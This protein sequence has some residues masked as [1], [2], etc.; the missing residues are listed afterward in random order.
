MKRLSDIKTGDTVMISHIEGSGAFRARLSEMGFVAGK[1]VQKVFSSPVNNPIVFKLMGSQIALRKSEADLILVT[2]PG[3]NIPIPPHPEGPALETSANTPSSKSQSPNL[4][5]MLPHADHDGGCP[6]CGPSKN[7]VTMDTPLEEG[8]LTIA[9][10]GNPNCG[11][12]SLFNAASGG[13]E[14][15]GN[16]SGV[17]VSCVVGKMVFEGRKIRFVDLPGTYSLRAFSPEEAFVSHELESG[18]IDAV[19]NVLDVNNL[20]RNL[21]LT[22][23]L[24]ERDL[25]I[26]GALNMYDEFEDSQSTLDIK[27]LG[28]RLDIPFYPTVA[29]KGTGISKLLRKAIELGDQHVALHRSGVKGHTHEAAC[30]HDPEHCTCGQTPDPTPKE[31]IQPEEACSCPERE[32]EDA[33]RYAHIAQVLDGIYM[34]KQGHNNQVTQKMDRFLA[35]RWIAYPLFVIIMWFIFWATFTIGQYP[36]DWID[37][38]VAW[39]T[40]VCQEHLPEGTLQALICDGI[41]GGVGSVIVFL[42]NILI[43]YF[44]ISILEDSGYLARAAMLAD[45]LFNKLG[46]HGKSFIPMLMG[47]GCNVPAIMSTRTIENPKSRLVTMLVT[48]MMSCS[49]R[50]PVYVVFAGAFF[51]RNASVVMLC[52]YLWGTGMAL[53]AAWVFSKIFMKQYES[54]FVMELPPYR[55]PTSRDV[56]RHTWEKGRQYLRKMGGI[57]LVASIV[58]WA[59]GYFPVGDGKMSEAEHQEQSFMGQIGHAIEPVIHPL[60][61]DWRMGVGI[62]AGVGA[63]ELMV[64]TLGVLYNCTADDAEAETTED[65]SQTHLAQLLSQS[66]TPEAALS[67]MIFALFYF[68][69]LATIAAV[70]GESGSWKWPLF[71]AAYTTILAYVMAFAVYHIALLV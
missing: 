63:K 49:A 50:I 41:L 53:F 68:P 42:A 47:Y 17:T 19:I 55:M 52:L 60:G 9:L 51:P 29:R 34:P 18:R 28:N 23:Q 48:P 43:L 36:M 45:P 1:T 35:N 20:E 11:K 6:N 4:Q 26:V 5:E 27:A 54:N 58:I 67:Y 25:P 44:F 7:R 24:K 8:E 32:Q 69:C 16:Y 40:G 70:K 46:L 10:V 31:K 30:C 66:T 33:A 37:N 64:S 62:I 13:H 71:T 14:R 2:S 12:T 61:Y 56:C 65:A 15:T 59:L 38:F 57:I 21:L 3:E 39:L 22:L